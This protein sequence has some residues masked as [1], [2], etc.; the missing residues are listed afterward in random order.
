MLSSE[1]AL[2][3]I[4][5]AA[6]TCANQAKKTNHAGVVIRLCFRWVYWVSCCTCGYNNPNS[7]LVWRF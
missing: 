7:A 2:Q 3:L 6:T 4:V 5:T 1:V